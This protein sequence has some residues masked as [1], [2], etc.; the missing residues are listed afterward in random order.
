MGNRH[1]KEGTLL[2]ERYLIQGV[3][4]EGGFGIT[5]AAENRRISL[6]VAVKELFWREHVR[7]EA[8]ESQAISVI[9]EEEKPDYETLKEK[10]LRE[11]RLL[12]DFEREPGVVRVLDYFEA[13]NTAYLVME[14]LEGLTFRQYMKKHGVFDPEELFRRLV[15][16]MESLSHIHQSGVIHRDISPDNIMILE[17]GTFK[18]LDFGAARNYKTMTGGQYTAI[19]RENY[20]PGEQF[21]RNGRQGPWTDIYALC[22][23]IYE[24]VTGCPPES[25]VQRLFLDEL[26]RPSEMGISIE[27]SYE[28]IIMKGLEM[29]P[30]D[31]YE[32]LEEMRKDVEAALPLLV[33]PDRGRRRLLAGIFSGAA[34]ACLIIGIFL[35]REYDRTHKFRN[36]TT[37]TFRLTADESMTAEEFAEARETVEE[38]LS[39]LAGKDNYIMETEG[40]SLTVTLPL[41]EFEGREIEP[42][43]EEQFV[44]VNAEK[45]F[46]Y[47]YEIQAVWEDPAASLTA[48]ENQC[49]PEE[50]EGITVTQIYAATEYSAEAL[51][52]MTRGE[53]SN[54]ITDMKVRLDSLDTPYAFGLLYGNET[55]VVVK[56]AAEKTGE[57]VMET[58][59]QNEWLTVR[60]RW[61]CDSVDVSRNS[62][63]EGGT[64]VLAVEETEEGGCKLVCRLAYAD[65]A[66]KLREA[67]EYSLESGENALY[68][69]LESGGYLAAVPLSEPLTDGT[70]EF[71]EIY[72][73][74]DG[75]GQAQRSLLEYICTLVNDTH[76]PE[77]LWPAGRM[78]QDEQGGLLFGAGDSDYYGVRLTEF[79]PEEALQELAERM[80]GDGWNVRRGDGTALW[81]SLGLAA[82][83][84]LIEE[85]FRQAAELIR[86]YGLADQ[87]GTCYL[88]L[89][90]EPD[91]ERCRIVL[92]DSCSGRYPAARLVMTGENVAPYVE[93]ALAAWQEQPFGEGILMEE[94]ILS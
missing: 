58:L 73:K 62:Y 70:V 11:A 51:E 6:K 47:E 5:Y 36:V 9:S 7:R 41:E 92:D 49:L 12:R 65:D 24:G 86:E 2:D 77:N 45:P 76:L 72:L 87:W 93:E 81:I 85:G 23:T 63:V 44:S 82:D 26:K 71:T 13:N 16:M 88:C 35:Y 32:S 4:G 20:A 1:L 18:L 42:V 78:F 64:D 68:L 33:E 56:L 8:G 37:E 54:L 46:Q 60:N 25:A 91:G 40:A 38:R 84:H 10:F 19:A 39:E 80:A 79:P 28:N 27:T 55:N 61:Y 17:E 15:P 74:N 29:S 34:L 94:P 3:L 48:G 21:D 75:D 22:A 90:D 57:P 59:G 67:S 30:E 53:W 31:R 14:Y 66:E 83:E 69:Q 52:Q 43:L 50:V 89:T